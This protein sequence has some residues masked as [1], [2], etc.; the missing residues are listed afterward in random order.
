M[1][2]PAG[3]YLV[4]DLCYVMHPEW[5][6]ACDLFFAGRDDHGC[7]Q[8][9]FQLPDGRRFASYNTKYGDG[10]YTDQFGN[11]YP[12]DA[13]LIGCIRVD[14]V[15]DPDAWLEGMHVH[16]FT[17]PF[18][19]YYENGTIHVGHIAVDT[20]GYWEDDEDEYNDEP[21]VSEQQEWHDFGERY[22]DEF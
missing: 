1:T 4:G 15:N 12:V 2:M 20:A 17:S 22:N 14:D 13:G 21:D 19:V 6:D 8:G 3:K 11:N 18:E 10:T 16:E 7:N 5:D 9:E